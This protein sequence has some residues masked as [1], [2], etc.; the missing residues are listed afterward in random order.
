MPERA[1]SGQAGRRA[2]GS[3]ATSVSPGAA[4]R[5]RIALLLVGIV[6]AVAVALSM[7]YTT[8]G[9]AVAGR[10][11]MARVQNN[12]DDI[13]GILAV[14][15]LLFFVILAAWSAID[16]FKLYRAAND[17]ANYGRGRRREP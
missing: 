7:H 8:H 5:L 1:P 16:L 6:G 3:P 10:L 15:A 13:L 4:V 2:A 11:G 17:P 12:L 9:A 14:P